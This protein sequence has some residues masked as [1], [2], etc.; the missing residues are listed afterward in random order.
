[1]AEK[2]I[3]EISRDARVLYNKANEAAQRENLDY[4]I[5]LY[6]QVL[7]KEPG[8]FECRRALRELQ[9][10]KTGGGG[11]FFKKM[12]SG[13][14]SSPLVAK[15]QIAL[16]SNPANALVIGEQIL[17]S[18]PN[19]SAGHRLIVQAAQALELPRTGTMS[20]EIL[21][22]NS[23]KDKS[24]A[25][26]FATALSSSGGDTKQGERILAD[27]LRQSPNDGELNQA[28]KNLSARTTMD[29]GG[30]TALE[31]GKGSYRDILKDK[32]EAV[33]LE[34]EKRVVKTEDTTE[35][36]ISEYEARLQTEPINL[37]LVRSLAELYTQKNQFDR[38]L[39]LFNRVKSSD[40]GGDPSLERSMANT[41]VRRFDFQ[42]EQLDPAAPDYAEQSAK[43]QAE[44][45]NFQL[46]ECQQR[47]EKYP[48]D[49][50]I[51]FEMGQLFFQAG[52]ISEAI[53]EF[54]K[55]QQNPH[56]RL[57][58]MGYLAQCYA[59]RKMYDM[60]ARQLQNAIKEKPVFDDEKKDLVYNLGCV[61]ENMGK[62]EEAVEQFKL[63]YEMDIG[64]KDVA[65]KVD[66][67]YA[68]Q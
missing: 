48:T 62:K 63:I 20:L 52:K 14:G 42:L 38:A 49:L 34:Q 65:A 54:Q 50:V 58:A 31:G 26:E 18:D 17:N 27:L 61:L 33:S 55:A 64:Y 41:V 40:M 13:A 47:V 32:K 45:L 36:L 8:F 19:S 51:R 24:L 7:E 66:A 28:L 35:R 9:L 56:K 23:P 68:G 53:L 46:T 11:G 43:I 1:M 2:E 22:K 29:E 37:K 12:L 10:K 5:A 59:K 15:G 39:E 60:A 30:Y 3:S 6:N 57:A 4:A 25:I 44:K 21:V 67:F 16:R